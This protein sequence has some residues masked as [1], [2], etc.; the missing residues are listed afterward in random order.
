MWMLISPVHQLIKV[1]SSFSHQG[2]PGGSDGKESAPSAGDPGSIPGL[3]RSPREGNGYP[4]PVLLPGNSHGQR[5]WWATVHGVTESDATEWLSLYFTSLKIGKS[6][7]VRTKCGKEIT[8]K[9][10]LISYPIFQWW[11]LIFKSL[12]LSAAPWAQALHTNITSQL[13]YSGSHRGTRWRL[14]T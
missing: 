5:A 9:H 13:G 7:L 1:N 4:L 6:T 8:S 3:G 11:T 10:S 2:F 12:W 14:N